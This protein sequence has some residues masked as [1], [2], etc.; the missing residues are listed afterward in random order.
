MLERTSRPVTSREEWLTWRRDNVGASEIA[1]LFGKHPHTTHLQLW[2]RMRGHDIPADTD[3]D[4]MRRGRIFESAALDEYR[5]QHPAL[6]ITRGSTYHV[7]PEI[8]LGATPDAWAGAEIIQIKTVAPDVY[9]ADWWPAPPLHV[10]MQVQA[11]MMATGATA[12]RLIALVMDGHRMPLHEWSYQADARFHDKIASALRGFWAEV[13][14][15]MEPAPTA[16]DKET[17]ARLHPADKRA[18]PLILAGVLGIA[19]ALERREAAKQRAK[20]AEQ[21]AAALEAVICKALGNHDSAILPGWRIAWKDVAGSESYVRRKP[22]RRLTI[23]RE[24]T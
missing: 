17:L 12:A 11:E 10:V 9:A 1:A 18:A 8:G 6:P 23:H 14:D 3:N 4:V 19:E 5:A 7:I 16:G 2:A 22:H 20:E 15:G 13:E 24:R 21:E